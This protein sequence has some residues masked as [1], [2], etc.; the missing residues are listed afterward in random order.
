MDQIAEVLPN[1]KAMALITNITQLMDEVEQVLHDPENHQDQAKSGAPH[2]LDGHKK[3]QNTTSPSD[4]DSKTT[5]SARRAA[6]LVTAHPY[7]SLAIAAG[8][9]ALLG[10]VLA[11]RNSSPP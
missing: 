4:A 9:G 2:P 7:R 11:R 3:T 6:D 10:I 8:T 5:A 1:P